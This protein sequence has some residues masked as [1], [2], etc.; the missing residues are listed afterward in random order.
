MEYSTLFYAFSYYFS[1]LRFCQYKFSEKYKARK[2]EGVTGYMVE[3]SM[4]THNTY[5]IAKNFVIK[6]R[7]CF[8]KGEMV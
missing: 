5:I 8:D 2:D 6:I 7:F 4:V 3:E 1:L